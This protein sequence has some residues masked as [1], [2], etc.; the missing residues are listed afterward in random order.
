M[1]RI[2]GWVVVAIACCVAATAASCGC[3][4]QAQPQQNGAAL[5][6]ANCAACHGSDGRGGERA[7]D[8]ATRREVV[9]QSTADL[10]RTIQN[11]L[12]GNGMPPFRFLGSQKIGLIVDRL[13]ELQGI[14]ATVRLAGDPDAGKALFFGKANCSSCHMLNGHGG[15]MAADLSKYGFGRPA[16]DIRAAILDPDR[17]LKRTAQLVTVVGDDGLEATGF[18]RA[19]DNFSLVLQTGDGA[20]HLFQRAKVA[21]LEYS[22]HSSMPLDYDKQLTRSEIDN[23]VSYLLKA[24]QVKENGTENAK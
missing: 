22:G 10:V 14:G 13:R 23:L 21:H 4:A 11:G 15:Y 2:V 1:H 5:F 9:S 19:Q 18:I 3:S 24:G 17:A 6:S 7:P 16:E 8:I 12:P 20:F